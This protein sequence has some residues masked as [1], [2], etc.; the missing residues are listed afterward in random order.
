MLGKLEKIDLRDIWK[1]EA[2]DFTKW[3]SEPENISLLSDEIG[4]D[5]QIISTEASVG[6]FSADILA[7]DPN[8][9]EKIIIENQLEITNHDHL[10]K[11]ITY[12]SGVEANYI[13]GIC[14]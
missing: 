5:I 6:N 8:T 13:I 12:A 10:G 1:H 2:N 4:I 11:L 14:T 3:L 7:E 9:G